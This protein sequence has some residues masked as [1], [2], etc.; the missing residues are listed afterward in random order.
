MSMVLLLGVMFVSGIQPIFMVSSLIVIVFLY[1]LYVWSFMGSYWFSYVLIMVM[2]SG[3][4]VVFTY[5]VSLIP[6]EVFETYNLVFLVM[7]MLM[8][9]GGFYSMYFLDK[10]FVSFNLWISYLGM[11]SLYLVI[12]LLGIMIMVVWISNLN[13]GAVRVI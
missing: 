2:L 5:M 1:S 8:M 12:Y 13:E 6:N 4:L 3:V 9:V 10:G 7:F 11:F